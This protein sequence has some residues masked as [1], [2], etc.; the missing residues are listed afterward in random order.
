MTFGFRAK[1]SKAPARK[2]DSASRPVIEGL[3][4]RVFLSS[5]RFVRPITSLY[6]GAVIRVG[7]GTPD[8]YSPT[9]IRHLYGLDKLDAPD[10]NFPLYTNSGDFQTIVVIGAPARFMNDVPMGREGNINLFHDN[11][12]VIGPKTSVFETP[13][14]GF[15]PTTSIDS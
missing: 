12:G 13:I 10:P 14:P 6:S 2:L 8:A 11:Q 9:Q 15:D 3:E 4:E 1:K 7:G 5:H